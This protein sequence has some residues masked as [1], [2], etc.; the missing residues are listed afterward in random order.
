MMVLDPAWCLVV[1]IP[2]E[3]PGWGECYRDRGRALYPVSPPSLLVLAR[4]RLLRTA[5]TLDIVIRAVACT[6]DTGTCLSGAGG[7]VVDSRSASR[8]QPPHMI[9]LSSEVGSKLP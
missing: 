2:E 5:A 3:K 6:E 8:L 7:C 9:G 4:Q 1:V